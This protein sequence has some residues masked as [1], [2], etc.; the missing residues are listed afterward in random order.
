MARKKNPNPFHHRRHGTVRVAGRV[1]DYADWRLNEVPYYKIRK[2]SG[3]TSRWLWGRRSGSIRDYAVMH[4]RGENEAA[5]EA[6]KARR[7]LRVAQARLR[8]ANMDRVLERIDDIK[9][10]RRKHGRYRKRDK[11]YLP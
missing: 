10:L 4:I 7:A 3:R 2:A 6:A 11:K 9:Y 5:L 1:G 8:R